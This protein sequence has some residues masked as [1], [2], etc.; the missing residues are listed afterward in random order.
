VSAPLEPAL[1]PE[2]NPEPIPDPGPALP[3]SLPPDTDFWPAFL[4]ALKGR[5]KIGVYNIL[6][7]P[8]QTAGELGSDSLTISAT[9]FALRRLSAAETEMLLKNT[10][11]GILGR[12][13]TLRFAER[14]REKIQ[15][16]EKLDALSK[17]DNVRLLD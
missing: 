10:A 12:A 9:G 15:P 1:E 14:S 3:P 7:D 17:F 6:T 13:V 4:T 11:A 8:A 16:S 2:S 5:L